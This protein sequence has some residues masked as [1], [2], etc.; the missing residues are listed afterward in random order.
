MPGPHTAR[1]QKAAV[2]STV[3]RLTDEERQQ[4]AWESV[5]LT[6]ERLTG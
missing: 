5:T 6:L 2:T 1:G 3:E 4:M